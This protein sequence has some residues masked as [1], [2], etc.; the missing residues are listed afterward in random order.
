M[1]FGYHLICLFRSDT[2]AQAQ[3]WSG[4]ARLF[5][6]TQTFLQHVNSML[7]NSPTNPAHHMCTHADTKQG[8]R[9]RFCVPPRMDAKPT[10]LVSG[11]ITGQHTDII[12]VTF[13]LKLSKIQ[14]RESILSLRAYST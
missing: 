7:N 13:L 1:H 6:D 4:S 14:M 5:R 9:D 11:V 12:R 10:L 8:Q 3:K 2:N